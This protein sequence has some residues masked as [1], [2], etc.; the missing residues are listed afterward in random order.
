V[1]DE[2]ALLQH[3]AHSSDLFAF[4]L[5]HKALQEARNY[6]RGDATSNRINNPRRRFGRPATG[7]AP[8]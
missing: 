7:A 4:D 5:A 6:P 1:E 8:A 2:R 3:D